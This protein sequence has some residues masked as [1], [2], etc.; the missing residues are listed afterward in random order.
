MFLL[1]NPKSFSGPIP[2]TYPRFKYNIS[3]NI[4]IN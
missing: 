2:R 4:T 1:Q 3:G